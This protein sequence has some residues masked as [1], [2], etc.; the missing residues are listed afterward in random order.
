MVH[1]GPH[2][3][4]ARHLFLRPERACRVGG[5]HRCDRPPL[6]SAERGLGLRQQPRRRYGALAS[7][8][9]IAFAGFSTAK[10]TPATTAAASASRPV[11]LMM[12]PIRIPILRSRPTSL[13]YST[14]MV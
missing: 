13:P 10:V 2:D 12:L 11:C 7:P 14:A 8:P 6:S 5:V 3:H 9:L 4:A 1:V